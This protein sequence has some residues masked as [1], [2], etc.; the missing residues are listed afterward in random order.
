LEESLHDYSK[1]NYNKIFLLLIKSS[2]SSAKNGAHHRISSLQP[3][4]RSVGIELGKD[5]VR[6]HF[7]LTGKYRVATHSNLYS[8][9]ITR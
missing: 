6:D 8:P 3:L 4:V 1:M 5:R 9:N 2:L 7:H